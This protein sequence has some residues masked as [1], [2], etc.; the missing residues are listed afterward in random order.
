MLSATPD[1]QVSI[2][3]NRVMVTSTYVEWT[4]RANQLMFYCQGLLVSAELL[5]IARCC[6]LWKN[7]MFRSLL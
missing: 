6:A 2:M 4:L 3:L 5:R 1:G 7:S